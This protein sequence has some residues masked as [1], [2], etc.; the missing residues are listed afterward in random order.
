MTSMTHTLTHPVH[1]TAC[2]DVQGSDD[3]YPIRRIFCVGRNYADHAREMGRDPEREAPFFFTKFADAFV[4][5][6][7]PI[8]Y[9]PETSNFQYEME[10]VVAL[11]SPVFR[12]ASAQAQAAI[13]GFACGLDM[14]RRDL[15]LEARDRGRPWDI[16]KSFE[17]SA[18]MGPLRRLA[19]SGPMLSGAITLRVNNKVR[20]SADIGDLIWSVVD[21]IAILSKFYRLGAGDLI[22]TGTPAGVGPVVPG[23]HISGEIEGLMPVNTTILPHRA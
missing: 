6:G 5:S 13:F 12:A 23:D 8:C 7:Q 2:A 20:Q 9:P 19:E 15:Q 11:K 1:P 4:P 18:V 16:G 10:L 21:V 22:F 17:E 3:L 14:T